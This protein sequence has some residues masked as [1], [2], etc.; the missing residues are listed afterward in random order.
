MKTFKRITVILLVAIMVVSVVACRHATGGR[1]GE[2]HTITSGDLAS[3]GI[4]IDSTTYKKTSEV[5]VIVPNTTGYVAMSD[6]SSW[7]TYYSGSNDVYKGVF[8]NGRKVTLSP[9]II[10]QYEVT[11]E[12]YQV[13]MQSD[14]SV[15]ATP[16]YCKSNP[17][18]GEYQVKRPVEYLTWYDA[19]YFCNALTKLTMSEEDCVYTITDIIRDETAK[20]I[21][22]A[23]V[24]MDKTK[25]GYRLPTEAE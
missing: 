3:S 6:D 23:T 10:S 1:A 5:Y 4:K 7:S 17:S 18:T 12:L 15:N 2:S 19:V 9:F 22:S 8:I 16:S 14:T 20:Q 25:K 24:S 21:T 11:Q 13:V